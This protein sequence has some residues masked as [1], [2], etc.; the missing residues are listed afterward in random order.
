MTDVELDARVTALEEN[1]G[2]GTDNGKLNDKFLD[3]H[4]FI[5]N[6]K[7]IQACTK[8]YWISYVLETIA[9]TVY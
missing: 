6:M 5:N 8:E 9:S 3:T 4:M 2:V 7:I 1:S